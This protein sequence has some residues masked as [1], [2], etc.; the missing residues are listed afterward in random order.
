MRILKRRLQILH[1]W[2]SKAIGE[3]ESKYSLYGRIYIFLVFALSLP[4]GFIYLKNNLFVIEFMELAHT[5]VTVSM[6]TMATVSINIIE[7]NLLLSF[8]F[9]SRCILHIKR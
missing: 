4:P 5:Y 9:A 1:A 8:F 7:Y 3:E 2:P 6:S